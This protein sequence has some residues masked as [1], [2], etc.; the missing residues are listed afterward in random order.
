M[1][2]GQPKE[3]NEFRESNLNYSLDVL[4]VELSY[5]QRGKQAG[6]ALG[7]QPRLDYTW[8]DWLAKIAWAELGHA[9]I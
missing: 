9:Q 2:Y 6:T 4:K 8:L 1:V 7:S 3:Q 5:P